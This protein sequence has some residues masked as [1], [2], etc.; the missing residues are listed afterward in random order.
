MYGKNHYNIVISL[1][2]IKITA[3]G[4]Q[5][6]RTKAAST[7]GSHSSI[8][9]GTDPSSSSPY[10]Q[11]STAGVVGRKEPQDDPCL[12]RES[13]WLVLASFTFSLVGQLYLIK[14]SCASDTVIATSLER[15]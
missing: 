4:G 10:A 12:P 9:S 8:I 1:Q 5:G 15:A 2:L 11:D 6:L 14:Y 13:S 3:G 7:P